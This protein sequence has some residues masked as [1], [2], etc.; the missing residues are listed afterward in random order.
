MMIFVVVGIASGGE[1]GITGGGFGVGGVA[2]IDVGDGGGGG[3]RG[4]AALT[5]AIVISGSAAVVT[6]EITGLVALS[7]SARGE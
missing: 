5:V 6:A 2:G 1:V 7:T 3:G 4:N